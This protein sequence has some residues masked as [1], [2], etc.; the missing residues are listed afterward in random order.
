MIEEMLDVE[1]MGCNSRISSAYRYRLEENEGR[2]EATSQMKVTKRRGPG[3][4]LGEFPK[5]LE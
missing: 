1:F 5:E 2:R 3:Q 4:I